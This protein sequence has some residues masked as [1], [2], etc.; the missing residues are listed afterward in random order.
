MLLVSRWSLSVL[1]STEE[2]VLLHSTLQGAL[3]D[4]VLVPKPSPEST[5]AGAAAVAGGRG[6][7]PADAAA[8]ETGDPGGAGSSV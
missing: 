5:P 8:A 1:H 3:Q 7:T 4:G 6:Q 2:P